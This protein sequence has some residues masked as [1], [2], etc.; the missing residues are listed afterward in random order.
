MTQVAHRRP[1][2]RC[3]FLAAIFLLSFQACFILSETEIDIALD[4]DDPSTVSQPVVNGEE[5]G[6]DVHPSAVALLVDA[7]A[8]ISSS[9]IKSLHTITCTGT[10]IA[11]DVVLTARHC[12][13]LLLRGARFGTPV[14]ELLE[15]HYF[16]SFEPDLTQLVEEETAR[17][18]ADA[19][20]A[21][22][23]VTHP[24][25]LMG[26]DIGLLFLSEATNVRPATIITSAEAE[27]IIEGTEVKFAGWGKQMLEPE[28]GTDGRKMCATTIIKEVADNLINIGVDS[29]SS[30][31]C[32]G[33]SGGP[34]YMEV[35]STFALKKRLIGVTFMNGA[36]GPCEIDG[37]D[38]RIDTNLDWIEEQMVTACQNG[39]RVWC[40]EEGILPPDYFGPPP[41]PEPAPEPE[42]DAERDTE[43]QNDD[44]DL[45]PFGC[46]YFST[47]PS[48]DYA[49]GVL[50]LFIARAQRKRRKP[51]RKH[52]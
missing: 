20:E 16:I 49:W 43:E 21:T 12:L 51:F 35:E 13:G 50:F 37:W 48:A 18:P 24:G 28:P 5:C 36:E 29:S 17:F 3:T 52:S 40:E 11:P 31:K 42:S 45:L 30:V 34:T 1:L 22:S 39:T 46:M 23:W 14:E 47:Q 7:A 19:I 25:E 8:E 38:T 44:L 2:P 6:K 41:E 4:L 9:E 32:Y 15:E 10:L 27:Q 26:H 33:D